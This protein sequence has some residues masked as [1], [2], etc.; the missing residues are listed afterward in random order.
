MYVYTCEYGCMYLYIGEYIL[1]TYPCTGEYTRRYPCTCEYT[2]MY[3]Y[4][5]EYGCMHTYTEEYLC[6][7]M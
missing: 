7:Y 3:A 6:I 2:S 1:C 4:I 5:G